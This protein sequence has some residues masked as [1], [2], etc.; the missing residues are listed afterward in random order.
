LTAQCITYTAL[1]EIDPGEELCISYGSGRP[2]F[3]TPKSRPEATL[4]RTTPG[5]TLRELEF[6]GLRRVWFDVEES[7]GGR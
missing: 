2:W 1:R 5:K 3:G 6:A 7:A 4:R